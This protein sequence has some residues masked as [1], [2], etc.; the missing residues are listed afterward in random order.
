LYLRENLAINIEL[1]KAPT[2]APTGIHPFKTP[3]AVPSSR[4]IEKIYFK[5]FMGIW[6]R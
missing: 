6:P 2:S 1:I 5:V 3:E 4:S